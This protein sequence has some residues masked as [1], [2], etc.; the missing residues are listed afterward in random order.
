MAQIKLIVRGDTTSRYVRRTKQG[1][2]KKNRQ[3]PKKMAPSNA[4]SMRGI[5]KW[6]PFC[7]LPWILYTRVKKT[8]PKLFCSE[9]T[10]VAHGGVLIS[11]LY[12]SK[13]SHLQLKYKGSN[14]HK[15]APLFSISGHAPEVT[16]NLFDS[17]P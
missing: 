1:G 17:I 4:L 11:Y 6:V 5:Q 13:N 9:S 16:T 12:V 14:V 15:S 7:C 3:P 10:C 8:I 2:T